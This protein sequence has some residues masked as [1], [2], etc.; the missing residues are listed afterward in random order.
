[1]K[2]GG[3]VLRSTAPIGDELVGHGSTGNDR[4]TWYQ[5]Q[6][7]ST[8]P[9]QVSRCAAPADGAAHCHRLPARVL[10]LFSVASW[11]TLDGRPAAQVRRDLHMV[12][13]GAARPYPETAVLVMPLFAGGILNKVLPTDDRKAQNARAKHVAQDEWATAEIRKAL[14]YVASGV[15]TAI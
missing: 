9:G 13:D 3:L 15:A 6:F 4:P 7:R 10:G 8:H 14:Q 12:V 2:V 11:S 1:M 5:A